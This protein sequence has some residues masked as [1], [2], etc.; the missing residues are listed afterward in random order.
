M[1]GVAALDIELSADDVQRMTALVAP[2]QQPFWGSG[3]LL[4]ATGAR[5]RTTPPAKTLRDTYGLWSADEPHVLL[6]ES[7]FLALPK[8]LRA[9]LVR[10][11]VL[12]GRDLVP[13]VRAW[14]D[15]D[16]ARL[17]ADGHRFVWWPSLVEGR[18]A[19]VVTAFLED[20]QRRSRHREV[21]ESVW[22]GC[23]DLLP[24]ARSLAGTF[25]LG[26]DANC[27][28]TVLA[29]AGIAEAREQWVQREPFEDFLAERTRRG[30]HDDDPGTVLVWRSADGL[31]QHAGVT[32][33]GGWALN[34]RSQSWH[35]PRA[36]L[37]VREAVLASRA[38]GLRLSRRR[39][40]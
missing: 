14:P 15:V 20:G 5:L 12:G 19:E 3:E 33:G 7:A 38:P 17:Q 29:A 6:D 36:V 39:L 26:E 2:V 32:L 9:R 37:G 30:G 27:F 22:A 8:S 1:T 24:G 18:E 35:A 16:G 10:A 34:K 25:S 28:S 21:P 31:V 13:T 23:A 11:Q 40:R 4:R